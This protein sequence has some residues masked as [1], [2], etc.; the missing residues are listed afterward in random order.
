MFRCNG[1]IAVVVV[2][3]VADAAVSAFVFVFGFSDAAGVAA[4]VMF[5][6][7]FSIVK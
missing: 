3:V 7:L 1:D 2:A 5:F 6:S 4:L